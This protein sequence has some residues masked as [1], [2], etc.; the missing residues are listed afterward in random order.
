MVTLIRLCRKVSGDFV[1]TLIYPQGALI[2]L[3][4]RSR[5]TSILWS[6][7]SLFLAKYHVV[8]RNAKRIQYCNF[9]GICVSLT[10]L[11]IKHNWTDGTEKRLSRFEYTFKETCTLSLYKDVVE[12]EY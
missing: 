6:G 8:R 11:P 1:K 12:I 9:A 4:I 3:L 10:C 7:R 2:R 5:G